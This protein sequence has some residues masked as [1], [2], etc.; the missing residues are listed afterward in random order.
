[1]PPHASTNNL[2]LSAKC[3]S[4]IVVVPHSCRNTAKQAAC[5]S[6]VVRLRLLKVWCDAHALL[7]EGGN[8]IAMPQACN[9]VQPCPAP[10]LTQVQPSSLL[11]LQVAHDRQHP[12]HFGEPPTSCRPQGSTTNPCSV[13]Q[14]ITLYSNPK[15]KKR[16]NL[17]K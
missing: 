12:H 2:S 1:M 3:S 7:C 6:P 15:K 13:L 5:S 16:R 11:K 14:T 17:L 4:G 10:R 8:P 9:R